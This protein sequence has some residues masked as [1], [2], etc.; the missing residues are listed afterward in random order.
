MMPVGGSTAQNASE[1]RSDTSARWI[2]SRSESMIEVER[3]DLDDG[4][5][6]LL[7]SKNYINRCRRDDGRLR[8]PSERW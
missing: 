1:G 6:N 5:Q 3:N 8:R 7:I 2:W 4:H